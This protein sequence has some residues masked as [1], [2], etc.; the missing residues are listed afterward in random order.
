VGAAGE[1]ERPSLPTAP[2][3]HASACFDAAQLGVVDG[4]L[5]FPA[6]REHLFGKLG[7]QVPLGNVG[8]FGELRT[9][10]A[11]GDVQSDLGAGSQSLRPA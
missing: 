11:S 3:R 5:R 8:C 2:V 4:R 1:N 9:D 7:R 10:Q 6:G